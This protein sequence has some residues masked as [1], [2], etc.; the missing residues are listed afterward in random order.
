MKLQ[1]AYL[2]NNNPRQYAHSTNSS[3]R[4]EG[5]SN[6]RFT[7]RF[8]TFFRGRQEDFQGQEPAKSD[9]GIASLTHTWFTTESVS[10]SEFNDECRGA[11]S[12]LNTLRSKRVENLKYGYDVSVILCQDIH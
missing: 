7:S 8:S 1:Q 3:Q 12:L 6:R 5:V 11:I 9:E 2:K 10:E 4:P